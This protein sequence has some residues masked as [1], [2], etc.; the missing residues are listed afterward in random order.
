[1]ISVRRHA[2]S[3]ANALR[4]RPHHL[5]C[6]QFFEGKGYDERFIANMRRIIDRMEN[7][8]SLRIFLTARC[9]DICAACPYKVD[10]ACEYQESV[11]RKDASAARFLGL[12]IEADAPAK[13]LMER[14]AERIGGL[15][16]IQEVCGECSMSPICNRHLKGSRTRELSSN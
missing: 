1:M 10:D 5:L 11:M 14:A 4:L 16:D 12:R 2:E 3:M 9:D 8:A 6:I 13:E 15:S 7:D